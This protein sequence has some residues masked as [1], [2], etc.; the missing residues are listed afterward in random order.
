METSQP[1]YKCLTPI[2]EFLPTLTEKTAKIAPQSKLSDALKADQS[3]SVL[4]PESVT[5]SDDLITD[6]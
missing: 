6:A 5:A 1:P 2:K 4:T 3:I